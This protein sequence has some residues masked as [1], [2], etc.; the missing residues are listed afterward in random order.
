[1]AV[2]VRLADEFGKRVPGT[3]R[4][5]QPE[6]YTAWDRNIWVKGYISRPLT[7]IKQDEW[8]R[9]Q[10]QLHVDNVPRYFE[11]LDTWVKTISNITLNDLTMFLNEE[12]SPLLDPLNP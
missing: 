9:G 2:V 3:S 1:M 6:D 10:M 8:M 12:L 4:T 7:K 5:Y 11:A